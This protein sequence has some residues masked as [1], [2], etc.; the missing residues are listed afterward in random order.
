[1]KTPLLGTFVL[2]WLAYNHDHVA[3]LLFSDNTQRI[4]LIE[5]TPF[6]LNSDLLLPLALAL[7]YLFIVPLAQWG[8]D[9]VKYW[10][11]DKRRMATH[12]QHLHEKYLG[13]A[14]V[15]QQQ[16]KASLEFWQETHR[17]GAENAG[18][19]IIQ[20]KEKISYSRRL[21][22]ETENQTMVSNRNYLKLEATNKQLNQDL[23]ELNKKLA[24]ISQKNT[25]ISQLYKVNKETNKELISVINNVLDKMEEL[26]SKYSSIG[27][28]KY[29]FKSLIKSEKDRLTSSAAY[30]HDESLKHEMFTSIDNL[31]GSFSNLLEQKVTQLD[32]IDDVIREVKGLLTGAVIVN[33]I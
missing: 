21:Q 6:N 8:I 27:N 28:L 30:K 11:V 19:Q 23:N 25:D 16:S 4:A 3:K 14:K 32:N 33:R 12:H 18:Q 31:Q 22:S 24:D 13:Q 20:L 5:S 2:S 17:N 10:L 15:A 29:D 26:N 7:A 9:I 1:M